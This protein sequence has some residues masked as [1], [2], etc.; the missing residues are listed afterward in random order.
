MTQNDR[1]RSDAPP[2]LTGRAVALGA[3][4]LAELALVTRQHGWGSVV[5][6]VA[7]AT[8]LA[9]V[10]G[11]VVCIFAGS[12]IRGRAAAIDRIVG[13]RRFPWGPLAAHLAAF[14]AFVLLTPRLSPQAPYGAPA[15]PLW[16]AVWVAA[17][18]IAALFWGWV[19]LPGRAWLAVAR[20]G[21]REAAVLA[22]GVVLAWAASRYTT[23]LWDRLSDATLRCVRVGLEL[24]CPEV[25]VRPGERVVGTPEFT[26]RVWHYCSGVEGLGLVVVLL[27]GFLWL[28][29]RA[30]RFP[31]AFALIPL[32][33]G[34]VWVLNVGRI[35]ALIL[36]G[37][38]GRPDV[39]VKG[40]HS[41]AGWLAFNAVAL[42]TVA[43]GHTA[44]FRRPGPP[45]A[46]RARRVN[47][48]APFLVPLM[49]L[50]GTAMATGAL[51]GDDGFDRLYAARVVTAGAALLAYR[52]AVGRLGWSWSWAAVG[53]GLV[54]F[55]AWI[56]LEHLLPPAPPA[57]PEPGP[58]ARLRG[59]EALLWVAARVAGAVLVVPLVEELAFRGYLLRRLQGAGPEQSMAGRWNWVAA[60]VSSAVFGALHPDRWVA[61]TLAGVFYAWV[62]CRRGRLADAVLAHAVTNAVLAGY[63]LSTGSWALW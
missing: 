10:L 7:F 4:V 50:A 25:V 30:L 40:F 44:A 9:A 5:E 62:F 54:V 19:L 8:K 13:R 28:D 2:N 55:A 6:E 26:V 27:A 51:S 14:A 38:A 41:L 56:G 35:V 52:G 24:V 23:D 49:V 46:R 36:I 11:V 21:W 15:D 47:P 22:G 42:G 53:V 39:A 34:A 20:W 63:V 29:R 12:R 43:L 3:L 33:L 32:A 1:P 60:L 57:E 45:A 48:G 58:F 59:P 37:T 18:M 16:A 31:R 17:G 61:G